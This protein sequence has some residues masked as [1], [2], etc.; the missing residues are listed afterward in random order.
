LTKRTKAMSINQPDPGGKSN[1]SRRTQ[2]GGKGQRNEKATI[3][4]KAVKM[5]RKK[6][7]RIPLVSSGGWENVGRREVSISGGGGRPAK[8]GRLLKK[9]IRKN[10]WGDSTGTAD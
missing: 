3:V 7:G 4:Q 5:Q 2:T 10:D 9:E 6:N 1:K 8:S